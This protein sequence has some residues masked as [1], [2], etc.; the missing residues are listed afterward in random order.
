MASRVYSLSWTDL[1]ISFKELSMI[2]RL[3]SFVMLLPL[4]ATFGYNTGKTVYMRLLDSATFITP[5]LAL[6]LLYRI[7]YKL[8]TG[9]AK[10]TKHLML[11]VGLAWMTMALIGALP[12]IIRGV[13]TPLDAFFES[14][15]GWTTT[16]FSMITDFENTDR[17]ILLYRGIMQGVGG[18]GVISLG[19]MVL[20]QGGFMG[21]GYIDVGVQK[22]K[23]NIKNTLVEA[24]KIY[25]LY[26]LFGVVML[27]IA[28]MSV[29]DAVNHSMSAVATGGFSTHSDVG[30]YNSTAIEV[31][32]MVLMFLGMTSFIMHFK[33]FNGDTSVLRSEELKCLVG[34]ILVSVVLI[35]ASMWGKAV[36]GVDTHS[37][38]DVLRKTSFHV[39][40]GMSTA[41]F[42]T[43]DYGK[44]P[45]F[46]KTWV[47]GLMYIGGMSS[48]TA[49]GIRVI[50]FVILLKIVHY[51]LKKL[52]L[53]KTTVVIMKL[54]GKILQEDVLMVIGYSVAYLSICVILSLILMLY[55][56]DALDSVFTIMSSMGNDGLGVISGD[57][58]NK[59]PD[60]GKLTIAFAMWVG[61]VEIYPALLIFRNLLDRLS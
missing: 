10:S 58:W 4:A 24:W 52:V 49:G 61:R 1:R 32:L 41:G 11:T 30:Y 55:G 54:D 44:W 60:A 14:M 17:D 16:G 45:E 9:E 57:G 27:Y 20:L 18:L 23:P 28:G 13:L 36:P 6:Y 26:I 21:T 31:V 43:V 48:S 15:S 38:F 22:I 34:V 2:F 50:R 29:F 8:G 40:S 39:V 51:C 37:V 7:L 42:N 5:F 53:P 56:Y 3:L 33:I 19:M 47:T 12:F 46:A 59:M 25:G 35:G